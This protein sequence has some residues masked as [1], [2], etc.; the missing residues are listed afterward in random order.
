VPLLTSLIA[1]VALAF[2]NNVP[3][4][5]LLVSRQRAA[6]IRLIRSKLSIVS[7]SRVSFIAGVRLNEFPFPLHHHAPF[8]K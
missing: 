5:L 4:V 1:L 8:A 2:W 6:N 3:C 7:A